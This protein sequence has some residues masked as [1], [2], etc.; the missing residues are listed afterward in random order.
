MPMTT[1]PRPDG[2]LAVEHPGLLH[3]ADDGAADVVFARLVEAGHLG[4][5]AAD[6]RAAVFRAGAG[7]ALDD[8]GEDA[9]LQL[10]GAEVIEEEQRLGAEH[11][12]VVD[13]MVDEVLRRW[14]RGGPWRRRS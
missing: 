8:V 3:H 6:E 10:A 9:R 7:E 4:G 2:L 11:G 13:A 1:S 12:D 14:C 5:L